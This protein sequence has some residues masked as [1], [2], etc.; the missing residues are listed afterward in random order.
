MKKLY[1]LGFLLC[2]G[3]CIGTSQTAK[4][5]GLQAE[6]ATEQSYKQKLS[7]G[8]DAF[9]IPS[10]IDKPQIVIRAANNVEIR[11]SEMNR[12]SESLNVMMPRIL[13]DD[14]SLLFPASLIKPRG[15]DRENFD[16]VIAVEVNRFDGSWKEE[17]VL[18]VWWNITD[19]NG[20]TLSRKRSNLRAPLKTSY[21]E[22]AQAQSRLLAEL[23]AE[24]A[25]EI[26][27]LHP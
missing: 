16:Y 27:R 23:A 21:D 1:L 5:Y 11:P 4:F 13:A 25:A 26:N 18:D 14:L 19:K 12:W 15:Y 17:A 6:K 9:S 20:K 3:G 2:L 10:Y 7:V 24:V 8:V 22:L